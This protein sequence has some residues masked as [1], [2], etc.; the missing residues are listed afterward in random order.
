DKA[1]AACAEALD[2]GSLDAAEA[3]GA[4]AASYACGRVLAVIAARAWSSS[5]SVAEFWRDF[6]ARADRA[7]GY[8]AALFFDMI[9]ERA[10][11]DFALEAR[12]F[13]H[14]IYA[15]PADALQSLLDGARPASAAP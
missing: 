6:I 3:K 5:G 12:A 1:R 4:H 2:F 11:P 8:S 9:A 10:G 15:A 7:G 14:T 13:P